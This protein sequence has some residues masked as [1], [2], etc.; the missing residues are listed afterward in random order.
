MDPQTYLERFQVI[1][2]D[3]QAS[4]DTPCDPKQ[5]CEILAQRLYSLI[6]TRFTTPIDSDM[7]KEVVDYQHRFHSL[8][9]DLREQ[10]SCMIASVLTYLARVDYRH[11]CVLVILCWCLPRP[12]CFFSKKGYQQGYRDYIG[13]YNHKL[14]TLIQHPVMREFCI[15]TLTQTNSV[16][17][18][19]IDYMWFYMD[20]LS[21]DLIFHNYAYGDYIRLTAPE[22]ENVTIDSYIGFSFSLMYMLEMGLARASP[23]SKGPFMTLLQTFVTDPSLAASTLA[24]PTGPHFRT[25][26][27]AICADPVHYLGPDIIIPE[28]VHALVR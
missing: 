10:D 1:D 11:V 22:G 20:G 4:T 23:S 9:E 17:V 7:A 3:S 18:H 26:L 16:P 27:K 12:G 8:L 28:A 14:I 6:L 24:S 19:C 21:I 5:S 13:E 25:Q 15:E 2:A